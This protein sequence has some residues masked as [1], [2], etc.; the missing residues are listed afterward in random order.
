MLNLLEIIR[1][2]V[3]ETERVV[4]RWHTSTDLIVAFSPFVAILLSNER[5][6]EVEEHPCDTH[7][8]V[9]AHNCLGHQQRNTHALK[10]IT[11]Q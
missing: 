9:K 8:S 7:D 5:V 4:G 2:S 11:N 1:N 10:I 6:A 3:F